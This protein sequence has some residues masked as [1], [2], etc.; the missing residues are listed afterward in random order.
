M[1]FHFLKNLRF[2]SVTG[3]SR[4]F[5]FTSI[6]QEE[7][8]TL[9]SLSLWMI[10]VQLPHHRRGMADASMLGKV[11]S[12]VLV[13]PCFCGCDTRDSF[14]RTGLFVFHKIYVGIVCLQIS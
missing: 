4:T 10:E 1:S 6:T 9:A 8:P 5:G 2:S 7:I 3:H 12:Q 11:F 13:Q 14:F